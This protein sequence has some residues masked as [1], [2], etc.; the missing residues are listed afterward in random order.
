MKGLVENPF[1][2]FPLSV[3]LA[4]ALGVAWSIRQDDR[5]VVNEI[6]VVFLLA[7]PLVAAG[8]AFLVGEGWL[9]RLG[10]W[11][12]TAVLGS[13]AAFL[14]FFASGILIPYQRV[15][16]YNY[17]HFHY[18]YYLAGAERRVTSGGKALDETLYSLEGNQVKL[19]DLWNERPIVV[20]FGSVT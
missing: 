1:L 5:L 18:S 20:E 16:V 9:R 6:F 8:Y 15:S 19:A 2:A 11:V 3:G 17:P 12:G 10:I 14:V 7:L 4:M 13:V